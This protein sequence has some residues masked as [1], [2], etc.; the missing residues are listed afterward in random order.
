VA[1]YRVRMNTARAT[2]TAVFFFFFRKQNI[3]TF[4]MRE[5]YRERIIC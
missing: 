5:G 3:L 4:R 1:I 2:A